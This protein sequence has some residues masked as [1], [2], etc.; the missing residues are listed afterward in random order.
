M[1][2]RERVRVTYRFS[3]RLTVRASFYVYFTDRA[4]DDLIYRYSV[5]GA[6]YKSQLMDI[7]QHVHCR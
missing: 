5:D 4:F 1:S 6:E 7:I 3:V 2:D